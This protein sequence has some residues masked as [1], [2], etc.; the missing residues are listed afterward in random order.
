MLQN[1]NKNFPHRSD[2]WDLLLFPS[3]L[4]KREAFHLD[5][6]D[7]KKPHGPG[8]RKK[9]TKFFT[10]V[11]DTKEVGGRSVRHHKHEHLAYSSDNALC[12]WG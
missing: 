11:I 9:I 12:L 1:V 8:F 5:M 3:K 10:G 2:T 4:N 6:A 7:L